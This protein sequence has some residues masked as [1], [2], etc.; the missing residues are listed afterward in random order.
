M[1]RGYIM[2]QF[3]VKHKYACSFV[4]TFLIAEWFLLGNVTSLIISK[5]NF[6]LDTGKAVL[7][8]I[9]L[10]TVSS[11]LLAGVIPNKR[12]NLYELFLN[13]ALP[14]LF[15]YT[16][17]TIDYSN[18]PS[19]IFIVV[20]LL[21]TIAII[22]LQKLA[23][24]KKIK[25]MYYLRHIIAICTVIVIIPS[26]VLFR[27]DDKA[28]YEYFE[29]KNIDVVQDSNVDETEISSLLTT[30][31]WE[32]LNSEERSDVLYKVIKYE[33]SLLGIPV[34]KLQVVNTHPDI[35]MGSYDNLTG[36]ISLN[37]FHLGQNSIEECLSTAMHELYHAYQN[38]VIKI[39]DDLPLSVRENSY[40][41]KAVEW[42]FADKSYA[43]DHKNVNTYESNALEVDARAYADEIVE[44]YLG[45]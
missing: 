23:N 33:A 26:F 9:I 16:L 31:N 5:W 32:E 2:K 15:Y 42:Q 18:A 12:L 6:Y 7:G 3:L 25:V 22:Y 11:I 10:S 14:V 30:C 20:V 43:E 1:K 27:F 34:P 28:I 29:Q 4:F 45:R 36:I 40:F 13:A 37:N 35:T 38:S 21:L 39:L 8:L 17:K 19:I 44:K 41:D 24:V